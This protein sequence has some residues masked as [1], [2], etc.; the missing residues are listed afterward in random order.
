M[1]LFLHMKKR[2]TYMLNLHKRCFLCWPII[3]CHL[4]MEHT[5]KIKPNPPNYLRK[6]K[7]EEKNKRKKEGRNEEEEEDAGRRKKEEE[8]SEE[9]RRNA[10]GGWN[11]WSAMGAAW[12]PRGCREETPWVTHGRP[13]SGQPCLGLAGIWPATETHGSGDLNF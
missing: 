4:S 3:I 5:T 1:F 9:G 2:I 10:V 6:E 13:G 12:V 8:T 11:R 7:R